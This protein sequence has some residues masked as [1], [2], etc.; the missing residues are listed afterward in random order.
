MSLIHAYIQV[1]TQ[2]KWN[3]VCYEDLAGNHVTNNEAASAACK[4]LGYNT[5]Y[6]YSTATMLG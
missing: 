5:Y 4:Q 3:V 6:R 2:G 1:Y